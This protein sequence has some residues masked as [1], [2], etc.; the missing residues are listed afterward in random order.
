MNRLLVTSLA[1]LI[2]IALSASTA[3][4]AAP[5]KGV[6]VG[7][8]A[9]GKAKVKV[10]SSNRAN[11]RF[12][13][14]TKC[15]T[16]NGQLRLKVRNTKFKGRET[17]RGGQSTVV[18]GRFSPGGEAAKGVLRTSSDECRT[19]KRK[20][21]IKRHSAPG[22]GPDAETQ[23]GHYAGSNSIGREIS[24]DVVSS[25]DGFGIR[26]LAVDADTECWDDY[27]GD[28]A[29]D[30]LL[31]HITGLEGKVQEGMVDV[32]YAPDEDTEFSI[33]G[34]ISG[35]AASVDVWVGGFFDADGTPNPYGLY[36]CD[37]WGE[38][39]EATLQG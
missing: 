35:S 6:Y 8:V 36:E 24:F 18:N 19:A 27:D 16:A 31:T 5:S 25:G 32:Y 2:A 39:Y 30:T 9:G 37:N 38:P 15:G 33:D 4:A 28:G 3:A 20:F 34:K 12:T 1:A 10:K 13:M 23:P 29:Q 11:F 21:S 22:V 17:G 26:N 14:K 7:K